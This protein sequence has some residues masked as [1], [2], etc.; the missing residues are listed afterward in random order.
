M[1]FGEVCRLTTSA[2]TANNVKLA[3]NNISVYLKN[4]E[5]TD[6]FIN[7]I[8]NKIGGSGKVIRRTEQY[9][10]IMDMV[11]KPQQKAIPPVAALIIVM[12]GLNIFSIVYLKNMKAQKINGIYKCIGYSTWHLI[13]SNL[14]YV[15]VIAFVAVII[16]F[17]ISL[18]TYSPIMKLSLSMFQFTEYPMQVNN[19]HLI[20]ANVVVIIIFILSTLASS[21]A[22]FKVNARDLVQE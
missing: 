11:A 6:N 16:T 2:F 4:S 1:Q 9:G 10:S 8:S 5:D 21:K 22:L 17:P 15:A 13:A 19:M 7:D 3:Y 20:I 18:I 12:A 14:C